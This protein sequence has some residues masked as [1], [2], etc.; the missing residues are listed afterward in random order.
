LLSD[1]YAKMTAASKL[2]RSLPMLLIDS[3]IHKIPYP[4]VRMP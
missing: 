4:L 3:Y 2:I 1:Y